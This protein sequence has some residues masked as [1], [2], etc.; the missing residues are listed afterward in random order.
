[1]PPLPCPQSEGKG[2]TAQ[3]QSRR[4]EQDWCVQEAV[5]AGAEGMRGEAGSELSKVAG[6]IAQDLVGSGK[7]SSFL[8]REVKPSE[9]SDWR[10]TV[11]RSPFEKVMHPGCWWSVDLGWEDKRGSADEARCS[12]GVR[13]TYHCVTNY[14][15]T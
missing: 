15:K 10:S 8:L 12:G 11:I 13:V 1:M 5:L 4:W 6:Q 14:P 2:V 3:K 7:D 9:G